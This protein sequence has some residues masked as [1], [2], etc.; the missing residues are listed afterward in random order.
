M[1]ICAKSDCEELYSS[2]Q[3]GV[4]GIGSDIIDLDADNVFGTIKKVIG[5]TVSD[6]ANVAIYAKED[7]YLRELLKCGDNRGLTVWYDKDAQWNEF[8]KQTFLKDDSEMWKSVGVVPGNDLAATS[9]V[10]AV[11]RSVVSSCSFGP[12]AN[13]TLTAIPVGSVVFN[14]LILDMEKQ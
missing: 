14:R 13:C 3:S 11:S 9:S 6:K 7:S 10:G 2:T 4:L 8:K 5:G 1:P 12:G